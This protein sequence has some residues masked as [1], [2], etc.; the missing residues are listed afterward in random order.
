MPTR[1]MKVKGRH[2]FKATYVCVKVITRECPRHMCLYQSCPL[3][4]S[5][6]FFY[7]F[8]QHLCLPFLPRRPLSSSLPFTNTSLSRSSFPS[9]VLPFLPLLRSSF[10]LCSI[11][12]SSPI[13]LV[14]SSLHHHIVFIFFLP[15]FA[16][17][18]C[19]LFPSPTTC[20]CL[21]PFFLH[22]LSL[23][24]F[25]PLHLLSFM[26]FLSFSIRSPL[27]FFPFF[28]SVQNSCPVTRQPFKSRV[29]ISSQPSRAHVLSPL[30]YRSEFFL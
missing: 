4:T 22:R 9:F 26:F 18:S 17:L 20:L 30:L 23:V 19:L 16:N 15:F 5:F 13:S 2:I 1:P 8:T 11:F 10:P 24:F 3:P 27:V 21:L 14:F 28:S 25:F 12:L 6:Y 29:L 7:F